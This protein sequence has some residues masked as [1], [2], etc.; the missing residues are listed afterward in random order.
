MSIKTL[1]KLVICH[2]D[3]SIWSGR[4]KLRPE[5]LR[6]PNGSA[7]PPKDVASLGSKKICDPEALAQFERLKKEAHRLCEQVGVRFLGGYAIPEERIDPII[8][9]L[10]RISIAFGQTKTDFLSRY[11]QVTHDWIARHPNFAEAIRRAITP[12]GDVAHRL[13]FDFAVYRM[14]PADQSGR[15]DDKVKGIGE[16]LFY[17]VARDANEL[18]ERS[19]ANKGQISQ[20]A[21]NPL[22]RLRDKLDGLA[23]LDY[24]VQ[25]M[26]NALDQVLAKTPKSG[27]VIGALYHELLA[28]IVILSDPNKIK[29]HGMGQLKPDV[30][31][32]SPTDQPKAAATQKQSVPLTNPLPAAQQ[33]AKPSTR[34]SSFYF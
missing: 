6:L 33:P 29:L 25:P 10:E 19:I 32:P 12:V 11:D 27:P 26:V 15:L 4:K 2:I 3:C 7:L 23:F 5:D 9:E 1:E 24:R 16:R 17:E 13:G 21:L 22:R 14:Q 20:R 28:L 34:P 8:K 30:L 31:I 18:F